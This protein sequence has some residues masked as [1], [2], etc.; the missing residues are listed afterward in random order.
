VS[1]LNET[2]DR[3]RDRLIQ[4]LQPPMEEG[5]PASHSALPQA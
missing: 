3:S 5:A 2:L 4:S 1:A